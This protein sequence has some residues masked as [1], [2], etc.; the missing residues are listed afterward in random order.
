[1]TSCTWTC[2]SIFRGC[3]LLYFTAEPG[4]RRAAVYDLLVCGL[5]LLCV[6]LRVLTGRARPAKGSDRRVLARGL[7]F[8]L[9][10]F[11][12]T[13]VGYK[14]RTEPSLMYGI[15]EL[16]HRTCHAAPVRSYCGA[17]DARRCW[18][19][20]AVGTGRTG[21]GGSVIRRWLVGLGFGGSCSN[22]SRS[23]LVVVSMLALRLFPRQRTQGGAEYLCLGGC[24]GVHLG[25]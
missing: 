2:S 11:W 16:I 10:R 8:L 24:S 17:H 5:C 23:R 21:H 12:Y 4:Q 18:S 19:V 3:C 13:A 14:R 1:M 25:V 6:W 7:L 9:R 22:S 15:S 20:G